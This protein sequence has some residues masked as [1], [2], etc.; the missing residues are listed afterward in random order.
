MKPQKLH[1][2]PEKSV[3]LVPCT[4]ESNMETTMQYTDNKKLHFAPFTSH[5]LVVLWQYICKKISTAPAAVIRRDGQ[6]LSPY[7]ALCLEHVVLDIV[8]G[9]HITWQFFT[10]FFFYF[11][12]INFGICGDAVQFRL[13]FISL[14]IV[15]K[16]KVIGG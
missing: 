9:L 3:Q 16:Q 8:R 5:G 1:F 13:T 10:V 7:I 2:L 6:H 4:N 11:V 12:I 15:Q 14:E